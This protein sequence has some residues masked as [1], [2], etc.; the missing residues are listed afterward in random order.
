MDKNDYDVIVV[1]SGVAGL[2]AAL[3]ALEFGLSVIVLEKSDKIG[4]GTAGSMGAMWIGGNPISVGQG[5][6]DSR[7]RVLAYMRFL[8]DDQI[9]EAKLAA[10]VE[11]GPE[12]VRFFAERGI[13]FQV[14]G[15]LVDHYY[16]THPAASAPGRSLELALTEAGPYYDRIHRSPGFPIHM[17]LE[18]LIAWGGL[19]NPGGWDLKAVE[20]RSARRV[21]GMGAALT[22]N[23]LKQYES[24]G[25]VVNCAE[26]A[27]R[28]I[29]EAG[30]IQGVV[31]SKGRT[32]RAAQVI[33]TTGGYDGNQ[34]LAATYE[35]LPGWKSMFPP[36]IAGDGLI[37]A[38]E[39]GG[40]VQIIQNNLAVFLGIE[41]P[42]ARPGLPAT[43]VTLGV[44][45]FLCPHT[46]VVNRA[47]VRFADETYF[48]DV[49]P[50]LRDYVPSEHTHANLPCYFI[51]DHQFAQS[52]A[53]A[54]TPAG[55]PIPDWVPRATTLTELAERLGLN[56]LTLAATAERFNGFA[57]EGVD[58][59]FGR[60]GR[61]WSLAR[62]ESWEGDAG[63]KNANPSL[64]EI[65]EPPFYG[66]ELHPSA[67]CSAGLLTD[68]S[69]RV[70][71]ARRKPIPGLFAAGN[72]AAHTEYGVGYQA[73]H[74]LASGLIFGYLAALAIRD[75]VRA[76]T[77]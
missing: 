40:T 73:G 18:E 59:D 16:G 25:G 10:F 64:G 13:P 30:R 57:R 28:L 8:G 77:P 33:L 45:E 20:Q 42:P 65:S 22:V 15:G 50:R 27:E 34:E 3:A 48:Q 71:S 37:M 67:F 35:G 75:E 21:V 76:K 24:R 72:A 14:V 54:G 39:V 41:V 62:R 44:T 69:A 49:V 26:G 52:F 6:A 61:A 46:M 70:L 19:A 60:G 43:F 7:E 51:F 38:T 1:G 55:T 36:S 2:S 17:T 5:F 56:G 4:G 29:V 9:D 23:F 31:T 68:A 66:I 74:S 12:V 32:L 53:F 58:K 47:A 63:G 11:R